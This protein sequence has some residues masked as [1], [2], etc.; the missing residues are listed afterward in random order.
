MKKTISVFLWAILSQIVG[1]VIFFVYIIAIDPLRTH[2][3]LVARLFVLGVPALAF[4]LG[5]LGV[6]PGTRPSKE[7]AHR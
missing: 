6:L 3:G 4:L 2:A 7:V 5:L 1:V